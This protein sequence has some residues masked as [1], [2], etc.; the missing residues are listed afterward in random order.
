[1]G[2]I[3]L[4]TAVSRIHRRM[5][6]PC[7]ISS[8]CCHFNS[9]MRAQSV[10]PRI[11]KSKNEPPV[12]CN[13]YAID[14]LMQC[15]SECQP[16][17]A[18]HRSRSMPRSANRS[19]HLLA[20]SR[21][22]SPERQRHS[23]HSEQRSRYLAPPTIEYNT[24]NEC[25][26]LE[27]PVR[28]VKRRKGSQLPPS[29]RIMSP[30]GLAVYRQARLQQFDD[31]SIII[32]DDWLDH[33]SDTPVRPVPIWLCVFLVI[34]YI[35]GGAFYFSST[36]SWSFLDSAYFAFITLTTIVSSGILRH[37]FKLNYFIPVTLTPSSFQGFGDFVPAQ[38]FNQTALEQT[39]SFELHNFNSTF[40]VTDQ[41]LRIAGCSLYLLFGISLLAMSFNLV[42]EEVI[43]N[44][45][46][47]ARQLG[48]LKDDD[49]DY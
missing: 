30:L 39:R 5:C 20:P 45:K 12:L 7:F 44:V 21:E 6:F 4:V 38:G 17:N 46:S 31:D 40:H 13:K 41:E 18:S 25:V 19:K 42:Q 29:P 11:Y 33:T 10:D 8:I 28:K 49:N 36:E 3:V 34:G 43:A 35:I 22:P 9:E 26:E 47:V 16:P 15:E 1:M 24:A 14:A 27:V 32:D 37:F 2:V 48:I 23:V